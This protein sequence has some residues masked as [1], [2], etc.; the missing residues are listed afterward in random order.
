MYQSECSI[1]MGVSLDA[2]RAIIG[3]FFQRVTPSSI[4][5]KTR[6]MKGRQSESSRHME[7]FLLRIGLLCSLLLVLAHDVELNPGPRTWSE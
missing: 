4:E 2:W 5:K 3:R 7:L 6:S 1:M